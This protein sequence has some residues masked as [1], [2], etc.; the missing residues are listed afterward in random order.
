MGRDSKAD[1][2]KH[3]QEYGSTPEQKANRAARGRARYAME[4]KHGKAAL[5]GKDIDHK[6]MLGKGGSNAM[7]NLRIQTPAKNRGRTK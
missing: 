3:W 7:S 6:K 1:Y 5:K 2:K 4:K